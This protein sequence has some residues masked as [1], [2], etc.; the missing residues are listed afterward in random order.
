[1]RDGALSF[2]DLEKLM[3]PPNSTEDDVRRLMTRGATVLNDV[4]RPLVSDRYSARRAHLSK[5][6]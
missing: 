6:V 2:G 3:H 4:M 1:M 5:L